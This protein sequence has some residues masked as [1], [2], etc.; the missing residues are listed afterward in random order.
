MKHKTITFLDI[1]ENYFKNNRVF[2]FI[3]I[4]IVSV[5]TLASLVQGYIYLKDTFNNKFGEKY[6]MY[7]KI[8]KLNTKVNISYFKDILGTPTIIKKNK[9]AEG[10]AYIFVSKYAYIQAITDDDDNV[11]IF[12]VT[13]RLKDFQPTY[14]IQSTFRHEILQTITLNKDTF[15][16]IQPNF[17]QSVDSEGNIEYVPKCYLGVFPKWF[18]YIEGYYLG[19]SGGYQ[20]Y[21]VGI[22]DMGNL[23]GFKSY[24]VLTENFR[25]NNCM[26]IPEDFRKNQ[27][28]TFVVS[29]DASASALFKTSMPDSIGVNQSDVNTIE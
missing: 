20:S 4:I 28:N 26:S 3:W 14:N 23:E 21:F 1:I 17:I 25:F 11:K 7:D 5:T 19:N 18:V 13:S 22:N 24:G 15:S 12:S 6:K 10:S 16:K 29:H 2:V 8:K 9:N 27:F